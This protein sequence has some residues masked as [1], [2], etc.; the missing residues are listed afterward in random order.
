MGVCA[1]CARQGCHERDIY[2]HRRCPIA[3]LIQAHYSQY[4]MLVSTYPANILYGYSMSN[5]PVPGQLDKSG[6]RW[7]NYTVAH[8]CIQA[9]Y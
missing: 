6:Q 2:D 9:S 1:V 4:H 3:A 8:W 5:V 7:G